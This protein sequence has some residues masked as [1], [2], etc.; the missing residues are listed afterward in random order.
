VEETYRPVL[1]QNNI[2]WLALSDDDR[3]NLTL[4]I[5]QQIFAAVDLG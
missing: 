4:Q 3:L 2:Q 1:E 5:F